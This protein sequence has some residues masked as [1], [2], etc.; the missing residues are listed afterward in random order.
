MKQFLKEAG[1][2]KGDI[3]IVSD[4]DEIPRA[5]V[6]TL[7]RKCT[8]MPPV[9]HLDMISFQ[10]SFGF[11]RLDNSWKAALHI[12]NGNKT[13]YNHKL[14]SNFKLPGCKFSFL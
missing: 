6:V 3:L 8:G 10:Y 5:E 1:L 13:R 14:K 4:V 2:A 9:V 11:K 7:F 12:Y